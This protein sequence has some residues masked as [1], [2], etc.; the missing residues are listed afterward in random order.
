MK[1]LAF[2]CCA[3]S[4]VGVFARPSAYET[5]SPDKRNKV[6]VESL[7]DGKLSLSV[8]RDGILRVGPLRPAMKFSEVGLKAGEVV[9]F[10]RFSTSG[11]ELSPN[12]KKSSVDLA[13]NRLSLKFEKGLVLEIAVRNDA[14]AYRFSLEGESRRIRVLGEDAPIVLP[15]VG[16]ETWIATEWPNPKTKTDPFQN[17]WEYPHK[18]QKFSDI[19]STSIVCLPLVV[20]FPDGQF[21]CV[22]ESDLRDYPGW[23][24][25]SLGGG[26]ALEG[27]FAKMPVL[28]S[29]KN[30]LTHIWIGGREDYLVDTFA[31]RTFPWRVFMFADACEKLCENDAIWALAEPSK[32]DYS[33]VR[34]GLSAWDWWNASVVRENVSFVPGMNTPTLKHYIDFAA[35]MSLPYFLIDAGWAKKDDLTTP[36]AQLDMAEVCR[37]AAEKGVRLILWAGWG[38]FFPGGKDIRDE[39]FDKYSAMGVAG[40][41]I[42]FIDR[43]D[44]YAERFFVE[45][46]EKAAKRKL[47][48]LFHGMHKPTGLSRTYPNVLNYEGVFG[49]EQVK[50]S[51]PGTDFTK[52]DLSVFYCRMTAGPVDYT[53][54]AMRNSTKK[55]YRP[56][57]TAPES[58]TTRVHQMALYTMYEAPVQMMCDSP[59]MYRENLE[60][61]EFISKVPVVWD[62]TV[63]LAG[64]IEKFA[65]VAR[66]KGDVWYIGA[67]GQRQPLSV[68]IKLDFLKDGKWEADVVEDGP[69]ASARDARDYRRRKA[70]F[71]AGETVKIKMEGGGGWTARLVRK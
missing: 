27:A 20:K 23:N 60:C 1:K 49:L 42:D 17:S 12:Y 54:G 62:E 13:S 15:S 50:W 28:S 25:R 5:V 29:C 24:L 53:P 33:W 64:D 68:E 63:G 30:D 61:A 44:A 16:E 37:Y 39:M 19:A 41:K 47:I 3:L 52:T 56:S 48:V 7:R 70:C 6:V 71:S 34:P 67:I 18:K 35:Q 45:T 21:M 8:Y 65:V 40:F 4:V 57:Y 59:S 2:L 58:M 14:A 38:S 51:V 55:D 36:V 9:D 31:P 43:D 11:T 22:S 69:L 10:S 26:S 32:G 66:R 46:A